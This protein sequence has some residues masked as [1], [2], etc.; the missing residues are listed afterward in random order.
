[1][2]QSKYSMALLFYF[3]CYSIHVQST[4]LKI[5]SLFP[6]LANKEEFLETIIGGVKRIDR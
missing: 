4:V 5:L 1:M 3:Q 2:N 6:A